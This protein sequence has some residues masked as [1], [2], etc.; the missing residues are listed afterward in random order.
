M[1]SGFSGVG[2]G[3]VVK[4][5]VEKYGYVLS[6]SATT[7]S[8]RQGETDGKDYFFLK[9][10]EFLDAVDKDGFIEYA[11]YVDNYYGTP[12]AFVEDG[13]TAGK[14]IILE[15][16]VQGALAV[17][18]R[19][20]EAA[21]IFITTPSA[22]ELKNRLAGRGTESEEVILARLDRAATESEYIDNYDYIVC[23]ES[24]QLEDCV[25]KIHHILESRN[26]AVRNQAA[27]IRELKEQLAEFRK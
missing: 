23:N 19:Y 26:R 14:R 22:A 12:R 2:K 25:D 10:E 20:P 9:K 18:E 6:V 3:T 13:L 27:F 4:R 1:I 16:E 5:L 8:P 7:R 24:G 11:M 21:L 17:K 15:I